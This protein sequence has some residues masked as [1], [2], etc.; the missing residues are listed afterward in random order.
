MTDTKASGLTYHIR[1]FLVD[2]FKKDEV[3]DTCVQHKMTV[4]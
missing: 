1:Q 4:I 2:F 3:I